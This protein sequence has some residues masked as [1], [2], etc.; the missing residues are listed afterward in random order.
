MLIVGSDGVIGRCNLR[1][2]E[3]LGA[4]DGRAFAD[5]FEPTGRARFDRALALGWGW[6]SEHRYTLRDGRAVELRARR[7]PGEDERWLVLVSPTSARDV[8]DEARE[9]RRRS[10]T[11]ADLAGAVARELNDPMSIVQG[12]LELLLELGVTDPE[13]A[14]RHLDVA[15]EHARRISATLRNLRLVGR[16][17]APGPE[18]VRIADVVQEALELAGA[19]G[20]E[21]MV[22]VQPDD[23]ATSG[24][25]AMYARVFANQLRQVLE[26]A[27]RSSP[28]TL[29]ARAE[30]DEVRVTFA[31]KGGPREL[32]EA[33]GAWSVDRALL[34]SAGARLEV[35]SRGGA[36]HVHLLLPPA[37]RRRA[38]PV[39]VDERLLVVGSEPF[40]R[41]VE[42]LL[43]DEGFERVG[44]SDGDAAIA[45]L[46]RAER[47][48]DRVI[49]ELLLD[50]PSGLALAR[51]L[52]VRWPDLRGRIVIAAHAPLQGLPD[53]VVALVQP[54][55]RRALLE[56]LGRRV[57]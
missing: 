52:P 8:L 23:L 11:L 48:I 41:R 53:G 6:A 55:G 15:L 43:A 20:R 30:R 56:A 9:L 4:S 37:P 19:R 57:R 36:S 47:P 17:P 1:A 3:E 46:E 49:A 29:A 40:R 13:A 26:R 51:V 24:E 25:A 16:T 34:A 31:A 54:L 14:R 33:A 2:Q 21:V 45:E 5:L 35:G 22:S 12:R 44:A 10:E 50:G 32:D 18:P 38:R 39:P 42:A 7:M 28:V 27:P